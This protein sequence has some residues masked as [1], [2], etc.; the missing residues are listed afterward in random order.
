M[1]TGITGIII[2]SAP[3]QFHGQQQLSAVFYVLN[4][5]LFLFF[6]AVSITRYI[7]CAGE[8]WALASSVCSCMASRCA[9]DSP[10]SSCL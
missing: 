4:I 5:L 10:L 7:K 2:Y 6:L 8:S 3:H 9:A 1:G